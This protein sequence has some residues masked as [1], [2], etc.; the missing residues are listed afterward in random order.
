MAYKWA[1]AMA[2][3][4]SAYLEQKVTPYDVV[5]LIGLYHQMTDTTDLKNDY[6]SK[7]HIEY[8]GSGYYNAG[9]PA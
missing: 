8:C 1:K 2:E 6:V 9:R 7:R 3:V 5:V 4:W